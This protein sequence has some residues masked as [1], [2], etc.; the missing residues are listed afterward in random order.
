M[1]PTNISVNA[2]AFSSIKNNVPSSHPRYTKILTNANITGTN[3]VD[4]KKQIENILSETTIKRAC[5]MA[6]NSEKSN[7]VTDDVTNQNYYTIDV[8][9]PFPSG[10]ESQA[11]DFEKKF[12]YTTVKV[13]V[14]EE[15][16][17][18]LPS[19]YSPDNTNDFS[20]CNS[21]YNTYCE[22]MK[23]LYNIEANNQFSPSE[24]NNYISECSC[25]ADLPKGSPAGVPNSCFLD[26]CS[27]N[28]SPTTY[29]DATSRGAPCNASFCQKINNF[30][31]SL[32]AS[33]GGQI[34]FD[35]KLNQTCGR[36][37][38]AGANISGS[39][40]SGLGGNNYSGNAINSGTGARA[41]GSGTGA[42]AGAGDGGS[43]TGGNGEGDDSEVEPPSPS[44]PALGIDNNMMVMLGSSLLL[45]VIIVVAVLLLR[46]KNKNK[47]TGINTVQTNNL[48]SA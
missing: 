16:C 14:P 8:K 43:G 30:L 22:N 23:Y 47:N 24:F 2:L 1:S 26:Y 5:C 36:S 27:L 45:I 41:G 9:I 35:E 29:L 10:Y 48:S 46:K 37:G 17:A 20:K 11:S 40:T 25:L 3:E 34:S 31:G 32:T 33:E 18:S 39:T 7:M 13:Y 28:N 38:D 42:G 21:F 15:Q 6:K 12:G 19:A 4:K 44:S